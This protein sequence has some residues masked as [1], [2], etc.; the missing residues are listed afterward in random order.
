MRAMA[1]VHLYVIE[2]EKLRL[3]LKEV[4]PVG[5][6]SIDAVVGQPVTFAVEK[7][8]VWIRD[9]GGTEHKLPLSKKTA[10]SKP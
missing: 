4:V 8:S 3:E 7:N 1:D 5:R 2:T 6:E 10:K 9:A